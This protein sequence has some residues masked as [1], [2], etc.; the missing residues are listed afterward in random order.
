MLRQALV[1]SVFGFPLEFLPTLGVYSVGRSATL[2]PMRMT[3]SHGA[4]LSGLAVLMCVLAGALAMRKL[5]EADP[6]DVF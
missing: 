6:V 5:L 3:G 4:T 1:F 2:L